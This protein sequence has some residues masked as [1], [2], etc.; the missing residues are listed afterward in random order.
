VTVGRAVAKFDVR[1]E[2]FVFYFRIPV[3]WW[4]AGVKV[5]GN[6]VWVT[7]TSEDVTGEWKLGRGIAINTQYLSDMRGR[8][9]RGKW[10]VA[11]TLLH[12]V[13]HWAW[14]GED[15][16]YS[17]E[18]RCWEKNARS[19]KWIGESLGCSTC[20]TSKGGYNTCLDC[21]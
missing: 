11:I 1:Q 10:R 21:C 2:S 5:D 9:D 3:G 17:C 8:G 15:R 16:A 4:T 20:K 7:E 19:C 6:K 13:V 12:E 18:C 14:R